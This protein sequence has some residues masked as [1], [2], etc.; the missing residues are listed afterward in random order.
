MCALFSVNCRPWGFPSFLFR[1]I[2]MTANMKPDDITRACVRNRNSLQTMSYLNVI[3]RTTMDISN[4]MQITHTAIS[5]DDSHWTKTRQFVGLKRK[6]Y[7]RN[8]C[9]FPNTPTTQSID[10]NIVT[11]MP[12]FRKLSSS[13]SWMVRF[14]NIPLSLSKWTSINLQKSIKIKFCNK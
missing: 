3:F 6:V 10:K 5:T 12:S 14:E 1:W 13:K 8:A 2:A 4:G 7:I 11:P 9:A